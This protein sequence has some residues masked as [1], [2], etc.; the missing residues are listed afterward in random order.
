MFFGTFSR[1]SDPQ[2]RKVSESMKVT[3]RVAKIQTVIQ[4][5][6][7]ER[8][9]FVM[10]RVVSV[11]ADGEPLQAQKRKGSIVLVAGTYLNFEFFELGGGSKRLPEYLAER[12]IDVYGYSPR[13]RLIP[14]RKCKDD[15]AYCE[16]FRQW[17]FRTYISDIEF[18]RD[19]A[20][21]NNPATLPVIG[22]YS[23]GAALVYGALN[24]SPKSWAG[25]LIVEG[26]IYYKDPSI[27]QQFEKP[28]RELKAPGSKSFLD[29]GRTFRRLAQLSRNKPN[30]LSPFLPVL[31]NRWVFQLG[32]T[33]NNKVPNEFVPHARLAAGSMFGGLRFSPV[34]V[35]EQVAL[36]MNE[37]DPTPV[38]A[39]W[40]CAVAGDRTF[41]NGLDK[42]TAPV[43]ALKAGQAYGPY[44]QDSLDLL[45]SSNIQII[46]KP[47]YGHADLI[48]AKDHLDSWEGP[49]WTWLSETI[50]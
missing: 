30:H 38:Y 48:G 40:F 36:D 6:A 10:T 22:G 41:S 43:L 42:F 32:V 49:I 4:Q 21:K 19:A 28:C 7:D 13:T 1:G 3:G 15:A 45:G 46:E 23:L 47:D 39:D 27:S 31:T 14:E 12:G 33:K 29:D 34:A 50:N 20:S 35:A 18:I 24:T 11:D 26:G 44:M 9:R 25:A 2:Y 5:G 37:Y 16:I 17:G 8:N